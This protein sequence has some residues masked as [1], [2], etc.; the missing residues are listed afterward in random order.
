M[1]HLLLD[2]HNPQKSYE[3]IECFQELGSKIRRVNP[4]CWKMILQMVK[5]GTAFH[6]TSD[7][8]EETAQQLVGY[9]GLAKP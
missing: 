3:A 5:K 7:L 8:I 1:A 2:G 9:L 4:E 6:L